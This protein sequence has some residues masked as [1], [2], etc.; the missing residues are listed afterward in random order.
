MALK[1]WTYLE[2]DK[3]NIGL[4]TR[5]VYIY[6]KQGNEIIRFKDLIYAYMGCVSNNQD[7][8][9]I[10]STEGKIA[11]YS[12]EKLKLIKKFCFSKVDGAQDDNFIFT[13]DDKYFL[14]IES[15][16]SSNETMLSIY[17]T[18]DFS[19]KKQLFGENDNLVLTTIEYDKESNDYFIMGFL[20]DLQT[21]VAKRFFIAKLIDD[22]IKEMKFIER[23]EYDFLCL[24]KI[25]EFEGFTEESY[26]WLFVFKTV[27]LSDLKS[28]NLSLSSLWKEKN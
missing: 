20:R 10:K 21:G 9:V 22:E 4:T 7:L 16:N 3:Y 15:H 23:K 27:S 6:D 13:K 19:L 8:L 17:D 12:L 14:N 28:M 25:V 5:T 2:T 1:F 26:N 18:S 24:A 11:V